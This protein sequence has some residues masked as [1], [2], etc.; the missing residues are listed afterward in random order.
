M[1]AGPDIAEIAALIGDPAR[2]NILT[3]L[4]DGRAL[5]ATELSHRAGVSP[6]TTS[7]HLHKLA[8]A[9]L[10]GLAK[11]GRHRYYRL[12]S[13]AVAQAIEALFIV[14][15]AAPKPKRLP[16]KADGAIRFARTCYDHFAG[17]L[18]VALTDA[19][20][21]RGYLAPEGENFRVTPAGERFLARLDID[22]GTARRARRAFAC[23]CLDWSE[24]RPHLA[25]ALGA[26]L[27]ASCFA[28]G[29]VVRATGTRGV[30]LTR[31]GRRALTE[32]FGLIL[33]DESEALR[34]SA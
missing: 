31:A 17:W 10:L 34:R 30:V 8:A 25:G 21:A 24:R 15:A 14:A 7:G 29:W 12:A 2:A 3:A 33:P 32:T 5:T 26:A 18:G 28:R 11:Q 9:G 6:Q 16:T 23:Q 19:M 13:P 20:V 27:A 4:M 1:N 22:V